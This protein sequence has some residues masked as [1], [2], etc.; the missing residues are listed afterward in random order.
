[1]LL[2]FLVWL[3]VYLFVVKPM[4]DPHLPDF[5]R[6]YPTKLDLVPI[7]LIPLVV[8]LVAKWLIRTRINE[9]AL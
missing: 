8:G 2:V 3:P 7:F 1:M 6:G 5:I 9:R 4:L